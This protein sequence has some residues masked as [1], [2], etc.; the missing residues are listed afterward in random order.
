MR[1]HASLSVQ[2]HG[3]QNAVVLG[4]S[5]SSLLWA[6]TVSSCSLHLQ[7]VKFT[8]FYKCIT[9]YGDLSVHWDIQTST[10]AVTHSVQT[11]LNDCR[12]TWMKRWCYEECSLLMCPLLLFLPDFSSFYNLLKNCR[13]HRGERSVFS[14]RTEESSAVQYFQVC[15]A[16]NWHAYAKW[17]FDEPVLT[18]LKTLRDHFKLVIMGIKTTI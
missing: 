12:W 13:G 5:P 15:L 10:A 1:R 7:Q 16:S 2:Y 6:V 18:H 3:R 17:S 11:H 9:L 14:E 4:S 8:S